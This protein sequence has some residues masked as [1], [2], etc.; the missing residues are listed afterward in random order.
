[1]Q[2]FRGDK[3]RQRGATLRARQKIPI[4]LG[5]ALRR[6]CEEC[7]SKFMAHDSTSGILTSILSMS[8]SNTRELKPINLK[9]FG[10]VV[11]TVLNAILPVF[12][13]SFR[14][15]PTWIC[16]RFGFER[17]CPRRAGTGLSWVVLS[18]RCPGGRSRHGESVSPTAATEDW[19]GGGCGSMTRVALGSRQ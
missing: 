7:R 9:D 13:E 19:V 14:L 16:P 4:K 1:M 8:Y 10:A 18:C 5:F 17:D 6:V 12:W 3:S 2:E 11:V 15:S